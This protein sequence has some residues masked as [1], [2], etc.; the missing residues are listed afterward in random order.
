M[1]PSVRFSY[2]GKTFSV[3]HVVA[4]SD[5][6]TYMFGT[7]HRHFPQTDY[8]TIVRGNE[9]ANDDPAGCFDAFYL[10]RQCCFLLNL[11]TKCRWSDR[12]HH[13][14]SDQN[15]PLHAPIACT[16]CICAHHI[17]SDFKSWSYILVHW[18]RLRWC[19]SQIHRSIMPKHSEV[20]LKRFIWVFY[21]W[22]CS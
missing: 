22:D 3:C 10:H 13:S 6:L 8:H 7:V 17:L 18:L 12:K 21:G 20:N 16:D 19:F 15:W 1:P 11:G 9:K 4:V 2:K 14:E 5:E